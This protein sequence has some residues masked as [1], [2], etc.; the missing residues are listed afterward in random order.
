MGQQKE[1]Y[2]M[3]H[4]ANIEARLAE[5]KNG[6]KTYASHQMARGRADN[7]V[8]RLAANHKSRMAY[9]LVYLPSTG[10]FTP[11]FCLSEWMRANKVGGYI[12]FLSDDGFYS[13]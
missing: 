12:G 10:R 1:N 6:V 13:I 7:I 2:P 3:D 9:I 8:E 5:N 4:T 11:I